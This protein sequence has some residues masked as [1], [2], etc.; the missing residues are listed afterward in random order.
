M[1]GLAKQIHLK[2]QKGEFKF[3]G[4][5]I[6]QHE[7]G[8]ISIDQTESI[9]TIEYQ[10]LDKS[11][12]SKTGAPLTEDEKSGFRGL[13]GSMGWVTR[14]SRPDVMVNVSIAAQA[15]GSQQ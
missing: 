7:D 9:E 10:V 11:R 12:R 4:K 2:E 1:K 6:V 3:C 15:L 5:H 13:I 8:K 14:Q